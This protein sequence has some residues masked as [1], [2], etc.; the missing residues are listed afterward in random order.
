[1][2]HCSYGSDRWKIVCGNFEGAE[3]RAVELLYAG[4]ARE[5]PYVLTAEAAAPGTALQGVSL[6]LVGTRQSNPLLARVLREGEVPAGGYLVRVGQSPFDPARQLAVIAGATPAGALYAASHFVAQY[7]PLARQRGDHAPYFRP[8]FSGPMLPYS[9]AEAPAF[10]ERGVWTWGHCIYDY[11]HFARNMARL[12]LNAVTLWNDFAPLNL[13]QVVDCFH[14]YGIKVIFG[15]SLAWDEPVDIGSNEELQRW[16]GRALRV[17][18]QQYAGAGGDGVYLQSFTETEA[19]EIGGV[20]IAETVVKWVNTAAG[21][22]LGRWPGLELQFG[23]HATSVRGRLDAIRRIDPRVRILWEDCGAFPYAYLS[24]AVQGEAET[25][26]FTDS[27]AAL[28]P[29]CGWGAVLKGQV[30]LDWASFEHQK[31]PYLLGC[32]GRR[33]IRARLGAIRPQWHDV[34]SYWLE[35]VGQCRRTL[36]HL[37]GAAVYSLIESALL[38]EACWYPTALYAQLLWTPSLPDGE[39]LRRVAQRADVVFA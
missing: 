20:P 3:A 17:Y 14:S 12:G 23:L 21:A 8:L 7:L 5:V 2:D 13:R 38:E 35:H 37:Q 29:G 4:A 16:C 11:Q 32:A 28:R 6:L 15:Y 33:A 10:A 39:L 1:M 26:A 27:I 9:A 19:Q 30:C 25:L 24:R 31:G 36:A 22:M 34:Q 18:E